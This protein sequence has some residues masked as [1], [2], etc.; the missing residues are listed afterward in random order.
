MAKQEVAVD[1]VEVDA[2][3]LKRQRKAAK[4]AAKEAEAPESAPA[5]EAAD[6]AMEVDEEEAKRLRKAAKKAA[7]EAA[8]NAEVAVEAPAE[9][10]DEVEAKRLRKAA[11]KAAKAAAEDPATPAKKRAAEGEE[12]APKAK[13]RK[14]QEPEAQIDLLTGEKIEKKVHPARAKAA[15]KNT[16]LTAFI[17]GLPWA[18][19]QESLEK[20][21]TECGAIES[22]KMPKNEDG[23]PRGFAF[24]EFVAQE[25]F[26]AAMKFDS[27]MY[28]GRT[29]Y[30]CKAGENTQG[31]GKDGKAKGK[32]RDPNADRDNVLTVCIKGL[33]YSA[34]DATV[35]KDFAECR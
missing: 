35:M 33:P 9:E 18:A 15:P 26:D 8:A 20:D 34:D 19:T 5:V 25:G 4:K 28:G 21:F 13:K 17:R 12:E 14:V 16:E 24:V 11:K 10:V 1:T 7:K 27:T 31:N 3:E 2:A 6:A 23:K 32:G 29:I 30:V 22:I